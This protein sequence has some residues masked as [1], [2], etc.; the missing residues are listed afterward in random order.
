[1]P[2]AR[3]NSVTSKSASR[4]G[5]VRSTIASDSLSAMDVQQVQ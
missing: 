4:S 3:V 5:Y 1:L 2:S